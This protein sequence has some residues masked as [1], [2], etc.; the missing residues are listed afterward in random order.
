VTA[1]VGAVRRISVI[2]V[3]ALALAAGCKKKPTRRDP[4]PNAGG[5]SFGSGAKAAPD[6]ILPRADGTPP[7]KTTAPLGKADFERLSKLEYP[8]FLLDVRTVGDKVFEVRQKTKDHPVLWTTITIQPC[9][10]CVP[11][12]L[13]KWKPKEQELKTVS[14]ENLKNTPGIDWEMNAVTFHDQPIIYTYQLGTGMGSASEGGGGM[15]MTD[16]YI[17]YYNDGV[18]QIRVIASYKDDPTSKEELQKM[19]PKADLEALAL[20]FLDVYTH[21]WVK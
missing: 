19:A 8:G 13:E 4:P 7:K 17:A 14:L 5:P 11:M 10:D 20:S 21:E 9:F 6:L 12:D 18:N 3:S 15:G 2:L 1:S 16:T